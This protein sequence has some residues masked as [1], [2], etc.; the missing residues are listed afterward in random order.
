[1][2]FRTLCEFFW[3]SISSISKVFNASLA[4]ATA[5]EIKINEPN[6]F[7]LQEYEEFSKIILRTTRYFLTK[8]DSS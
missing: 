6:A 5:S 8:G 3:D 2:N 4:F 1:M 7:K